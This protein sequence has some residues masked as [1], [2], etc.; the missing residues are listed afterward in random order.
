MAMS[1][2]PEWRGSYCEE[3]AKTEITDTLNQ[4]KST[5][6]CI[7][8]VSWTAGPSCKSSRVLSALAPIKFAARSAAVRPQKDAP[9]INC[10]MTNPSCGYLD[11]RLSWALVM[12]IARLRRIPTSTSRKLT[13]EIHLLRRSRCSVI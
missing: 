12:A 13:K 4:H 1:Q 7:L 6:Y 3:T 5:L 8:S 9:N 11:S 2:V 10:E